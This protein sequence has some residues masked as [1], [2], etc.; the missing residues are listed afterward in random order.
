MRKKN[1]ECAA[2]SAL[3]HSIRTTQNPRMEN[4]NLEASKE[5]HPM[6]RSYLIIFFSGLHDHPPRTTMLVHEEQI[7]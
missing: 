2:P 6:L 7:L 5:L 4:L 1:Q 3:F